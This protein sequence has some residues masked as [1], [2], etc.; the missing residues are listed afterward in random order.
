MANPLLKAAQQHH[1]Q[2]LSIKQGLSN[3]VQIKIIRLARTIADLRGEDAIS[4][5]AL[6][7]ALLLRK[8]NHITFT[9]MYTDI[10]TGEFTYEYDNEKINT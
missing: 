1:L 7:E 4:D 10:L 3:R 5:E 2:R 8:M 9:T 6:G